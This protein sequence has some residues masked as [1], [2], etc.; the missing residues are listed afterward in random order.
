MR[1]PLLYRLAFAPAACYNGKK[2]SWRFTM[3]IF[4]GLTLPGDARSAVESLSLSAQA[5][6]P[7][8]YVL[9][10]NHHL[11]LAFLGDVPESRLPEAEDVLARCA[12]AFPAPHIAVRGADH[13]GPA[14]NAILV[15]RAEGRPDLAPLH[16]A[17]LSC[18]E[19]AAL[20]FSPGPFA[21]HITLARH[22][23]A[24]PEA[25]MRLS[26]MAREI[27]PFHAPCAHLFLSARDGTNV[28]R[29]TPLFR[30]G[31]VE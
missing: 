15:L 25:L 21:P 3:R 11:T 9:P 17:L 10:G 7:G 1:T 2:V 16:D 26:R 29:Y 14:S 20:P 22:V 13:F 27:P 30:A 5:L 18:L 12:A 23:R 19:K 28:L 4:F 31:F 6:L 24:E 8:R